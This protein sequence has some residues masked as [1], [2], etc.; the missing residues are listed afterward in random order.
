[1]LP[2]IG[3]KQKIIETFFVFHFIDFS[4]VKLL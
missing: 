1:M 4:F 2:S 3:Q